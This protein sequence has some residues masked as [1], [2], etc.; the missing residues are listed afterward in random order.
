MTLSEQQLNDITIRVREDISLMGS[1][2]KRKFEIQQFDD[3][4]K[5]FSS[6]D[7]VD[8]SNL[9]KDIYEQQ[10]ISLEN[11]CIEDY[12]YI[13]L[14]GL[15]NLKTNQ[16]RKEILQVVSDGGTTHRKDIQPIIDNYIESKNAD[17]K[18]IEVPLKLS[19]NGN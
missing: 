2:N 19:F 11:A 5:Q 14:T 9:I 12:D 8:V 6:S 3:W 18:I 7:N 1:S 16:A 17:N 10:F 15:G 13:L 4:V